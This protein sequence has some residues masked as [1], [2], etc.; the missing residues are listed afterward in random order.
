MTG[1]GRQ[2]TY[3]WILP[4]CPLPEGKI[5]TWPTYFTLDWLNV[6]FSP[7][8]S[9]KTHWIREFESLLSAEAV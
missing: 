6:R 9:F 2:R 1:M 8:R 5:A 7:K 4:E 3:S